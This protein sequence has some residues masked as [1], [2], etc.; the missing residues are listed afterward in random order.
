VNL[1]TDAPPAALPFAAD[2]L[3][4]ERILS[5]LV[6]NALAAVGPA[7]IGS[8]ARTVH[9]AARGARTPDG[10]TAVIL[11]VSDDGPGFPPGG[12]EQAFDRSYRGDPSRSGPGSG[13]GLAIVRELARRH[14][15]DAAA[16]NL[17]PH[18]ARVSVVLPIVP[19][20]LAE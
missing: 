20:T 1:V 7:V 8:A 5:N 15:G 14:G 6:E 18:G 9:L 10:R 19:A 2:R 4:V 16:E 13:L 12:L 3:A 11:S 17:A